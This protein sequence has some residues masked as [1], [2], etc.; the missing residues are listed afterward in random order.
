M[1]IDYSSTLFFGFIVDWDD[2]REW[3]L[4]PLRNDD[5]SEDDVDNYE[6][7]DVFEMA[8]KRKV[9]LGGYTFEI[10]KASPYFDCPWRDNTFA[11]GVCKPSFSVSEMYELSRYTM[12]DGYDDFNQVLKN[13]RISKAPAIISLPDVW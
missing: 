3:I 7:F 4:A 12:M 9:T 10:I 2:V 11:F 13:L 6:D 8:E 5:S 1:G